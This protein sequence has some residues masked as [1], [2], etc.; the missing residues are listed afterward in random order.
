MS[1]ETKR[2][3]E[4]GYKKPP[5]AARFQKG[6]SGNPGGRPKKLAQLVELGDIVQAIDNEAIF[7][8]ENG[9]ASGRPKLKSVFGCSSLASAIGGD[10]RL[11]DCSSEWL[12]NTSSRSPR[13]AISLN[14]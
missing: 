3:C 6:K 10:W 8:T 11:H 4:V 9:S 12:R 1:G 13:R 2:D 14:S 7:V 5:R